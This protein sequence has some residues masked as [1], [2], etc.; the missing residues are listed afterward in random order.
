MN[1]FTKKEFVDAFCLYGEEASGRFIPTVSDVLSSVGNQVF[2]NIY[3]VNEEGKIIRGTSE[4]LILKKFYNFQPKG[5]PS[6]EAVLVDPS[7]GS[8]VVRGQFFPNGH[9]VSPI[10]GKNYAIQTIR[11]FSKTRELINLY[12][13]NYLLL[14]NSTEEDYL[15]FERMKGLSAVPS[16]R[17]YLATINP[18][19][20]VFYEKEDNKVV[21]CFS[22]PILDLSI[23]ES[24]KRK[25]KLFITI[26][27]IL[28]KGVEKAE[29]DYV[30]GFEY[31]ATFSDGEELLVRFTK[32]ETLANTEEHVEDENKKE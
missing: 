27:H 7:N 24:G 3:E 21:N 14:E 28:G 5:I 32:L 17:M 20:A 19:E 25:P 11:D 6:F 30:D 2:V 13:R 31:K 18:V 22:V 12:Y 10:Q 1:K 23:R 16:V 15:S 4:N 26:P 29:I 8:E 9:S